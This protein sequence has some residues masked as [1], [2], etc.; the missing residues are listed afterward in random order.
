MKRIY[1]DFS[2]TMDGQPVLQITN[3][4]QA[5]V[6]PLTTLFHHFQ[7]IVIDTIYNADGPL[8]ETPE[9]AT[10]TRTNGFKYQTLL[11]ELMSLSPYLTS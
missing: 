10:L 7:M 3:T 9:Q 5:K 11:V 4:F 6:C 1:V 8:D 2:S